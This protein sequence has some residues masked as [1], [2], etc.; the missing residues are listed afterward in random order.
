MKNILTNV[1]DIGNNDYKQ[2]Q[3]I[4]T[5]FDDI[6]YITRENKKYYMRDIEPIMGLVNKVEHKNTG[7]SDTTQLIHT[8]K[9]LV[10]ITPG[11]L[12]E[13]ETNNSSTYNITPD[14]SINKFKVKTVDNYEKIIEIES[15]NSNNRNISINTNTAIDIDNNSSANVTWIVRNPSLGLFGSYQH[16]QAM[17]DSIKINDFYNNFF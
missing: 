12:I 3:K 13:I 8:N 15:I 17:I 10:S 7:S 1:A 9:E 2:I 5:E 11:D 4:T 14:T 16:S 6:N